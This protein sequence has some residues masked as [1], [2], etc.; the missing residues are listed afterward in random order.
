MDG[1]RAL[2]FN[3]AYVEEWATENGYVD[4]EVRFSFVPYGGD[5]SFDY[6]ITF[7]E[8][9]VADGTNI[10]GSISFVDYVAEGEY[11]SYTICPTESGTW[12]FTS[13][14]NSDTYAYLYDANGNELAYNDDGGSDNNFQI[15]YELQAGETYTL[16][17]RWY[18]SYNAGNMPIIIVCEP[19]A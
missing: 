18:N 10:T 5:S 8:K 13:C 4:Y 9:T 6:A 15:V 7:A 1:V 16:T 17:I 2:A 19:N 11:K 12:T 3:K 14:A